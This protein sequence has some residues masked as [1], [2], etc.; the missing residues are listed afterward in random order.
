[1]TSTC[2][3][4]RATP[5]LIVGVSVVVVSAQSAPA[6][7]ALTVPA[8][9]LPDGCRLGPQPPKPTPIVLA[10]GKLIQRLNPPG[11]FPTNPWFGTDD[12]LMVRV[13][14][15]IEPAAPGIRLPDGPPLEHKEVSKLA[16]SLKGHVVEAYQA[17]YEASPGGLIRVQAV[18]Y[19][20]A[21]WAAPDPLQENRIVRGTTVI[22]I[23]GQPSQ[24]LTAIREYIQALK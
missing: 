24:C 17:E 20:E 19:T 7:S 9:S 6:L 4:L 3:L 22:L 21:K 18:R 23:G 15:A 14:Q 11:W 12:W 10:D 16:W 2:S 8:T 1:M 13:Q 5:A